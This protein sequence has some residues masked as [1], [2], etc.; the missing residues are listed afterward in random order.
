MQRKIHELAAL[1]TDCYKFSH[2]QFYP[3]A[4]NEGERG[5]EEV[6]SNMTPRRNSY[7]PWNSEYTTMGSEL[8]AGRFLIDFWNDNFFK[9]PKDEV[10][11]DF[12]RVLKAGGLM[13]T[14]TAKDIGDLHDLGYLPVEVKALPEG[15]QV[16]TGVPMMTVRNTLP[17]YFWLPNFIETPLLAEVFPV[18]NAASIARQYKKV[19]LKWSEMTS[20]DNGHIPWQFHDFSRRGHHGN[21]AG[22]T[23][24]LGHLTS[25][26]GT[27]SIQGAIMAANYHQADLDGE[28]PFFGSV[29][30]TEHSVASAYGREGEK[31]YYERLIKQFPD[32]ILSMVSDTYDYWNVLTNTLPALKDLI[33][34]RNGKLVVRPDSGNIIEVIA[35]KSI[36]DLD[37]N[38]EF[39]ECLED[40][41]VLTD[42]VADFIE[43]SD[44][45][46]QNGS[47]LKYGENHFKIHSI[48]YSYD[49]DVSSLSVRKYELTSED[50]GSL[51]LLW[52]TFGGTINSKG[53]KVLDPHIGLIYGDSVTL[54]NVDKIFAAME[55]IGFASSNVV[56]G[57]G[58]YSYSVLN[59]RDTFGCA[60]K[61]TAVIVNGEERHVQKDPITDKRKASA[62]GYL[63][64]IIDDDA[65]S[66]TFGKPM[67]VQGLTKAEMNNQSEF[68]LL[69]PIYRNGK[70]LR[71]TPL[72]LI[73][74]RI[75]THL[76]SELKGQ[77]TV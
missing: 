4:M 24:A 63:S 33:M 2:K 11:S 74:N 67:L 17:E 28:I 9:L 58:A 21:D 19:A 61:T 71:N 26:A 15:I 13:N 43:F 34:E 44:V 62:K 57:I 29:M 8:F 76:H 7:F 22:T 41:G 59:T 48:S 37:G 36:F 12:V 25:F 49:G 69:E 51:N 20:D 3:F 50:K 16:P 53:Y 45:L 73:K 39:K 52:E 46:F 1:A 40:F 60:F 72:S 32:G 42:A 38:E 47:I 27:D 77:I 55:R 70:M 6:Y 66:E 18:M 23:I 10:V 64:V 54:D 31:E 5:T 14:L 68:D 30:A 56:L 75:D 65:E 35:G